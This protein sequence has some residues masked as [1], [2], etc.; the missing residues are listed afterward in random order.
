MKEQQIAAK[1][2]N[3]DALQQKV[4]MM[5]QVDQ[6]QKMAENLMS[7]FV[8][9]ELIRQDGEGNWEVVNDA[10]GSKFKAFQDA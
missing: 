5:E 2:A 8:S 7:Q 3:Y 6:Q 1:L 10:T 9:A 4:Q